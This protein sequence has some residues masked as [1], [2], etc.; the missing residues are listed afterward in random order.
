MLKNIPSDAKGY[1]AGWNGNVCSVNSS[2][3]TGVADTS[4][5]VTYTYTPS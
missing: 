3:T 5:Q 4:C 2:V 1:G